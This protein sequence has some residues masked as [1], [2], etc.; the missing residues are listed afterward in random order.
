M[1]NK[2]K[3]FV[4]GTGLLITGCGGSK[5]IVLY[6]ATVT[7]GVR[8][9]NTNVTANRMGKYFASYGIHIT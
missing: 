6:Q 5:T 1:Q 7:V 4:G 8:T 3:H 9:S 2:Q